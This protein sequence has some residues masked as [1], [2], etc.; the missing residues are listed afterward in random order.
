MLPLLLF[1]FEICIN[2]YG[3]IIDVTCDIVIGGGNTGALSAAITAAQSAQ[4][5]N[6]SISICL[7]EPID[8]FGGQ[9]MNVPAIDFGGKNKESVNQPKSF[10]D[11]IKF[12]SPNG[13]NPG[14]CSVSAY[15][16]QPLTLMNGYISPL[17]K[18]LSK[19]ITVYD[20][21]V[22]IDT[23]NKTDNDGDKYIESVIAI[24]RKPMDQ[25]KEWSYLFSQQLEDWYSP[26]NSTLFTKT[27]FKFNGK[28]FIEASEFGDILMTSGMNV[29]QGVETPNENSTTCNDQCGQALTFTFFVK[30]LSSIPDN[31]P[32][33][34]IGDGNGE[35]YSYNGYSWL[36]A[37]VYRRAYDSDPAKGKDQ[38]NFGDITQ[39]NWGG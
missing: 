21:T 7:L 38:I 29:S 19:Y 9:L 2:C 25:S 32:I 33:I 17:L 14:V 11:L 13:T 3:S 26:N 23:I 10:R 35:P 1:L 16:Y 36:N 22:I 31:P 20:R 28:I 6:I 39:Q 15:C 18:N 30:L 27:Q 12:I 37:W 8:I 24:Q 34:P 5:K 4:A